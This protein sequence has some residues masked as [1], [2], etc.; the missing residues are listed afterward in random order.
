MGNL[1]TLRL[2]IEFNDY[3]RPSI[4]NNPTFINIFQEFQIV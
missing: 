3:Y 1:D 4:S 2:I